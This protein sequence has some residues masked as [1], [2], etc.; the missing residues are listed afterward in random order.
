MG[1]TLSVNQVVPIIQNRDGE[2]S[3]QLLIDG[4]KVKIT[5]SSDKEDSSVM[6]NIRQILLHQRNVSP[7]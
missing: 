4:C 2:Y 1:S 7:A 3:Q 5:Y 6:E